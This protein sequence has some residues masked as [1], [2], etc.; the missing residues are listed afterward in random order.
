MPC[1]PGDLK[2][3][4]GSITALRAG[5][6]LEGG[7]LSASFGIENELSCSR[8]PMSSVAM[9]MGQSGQTISLASKDGVKTMG[10]RRRSRG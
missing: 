6:L 9:I 7:V 10:L 8:L 1:K 2:A 3:G 4:R 5:E